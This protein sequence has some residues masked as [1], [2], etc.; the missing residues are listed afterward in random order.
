MH[1]PFTPPRD[2][3][4]PLLESRPGRVRAKAMTWC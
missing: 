1:H 2:E 3:D 4:W